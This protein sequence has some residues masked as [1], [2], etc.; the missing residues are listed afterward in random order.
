MTILKIIHM[1]LLW[2][3]IILE[4]KGSNQDLINMVKRNFKFLGSRVARLSDPRD[5]TTNLGLRE[6]H[7]N[8]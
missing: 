6:S 3:F 7:R 5:S 2:V 4:I 8:I 1:F